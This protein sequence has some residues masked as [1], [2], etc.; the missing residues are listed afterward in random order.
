MK[1]ANY[2]KRT[3]PGTVFDICNVSFLL[4]LS[5]VLVYPFWNQLIISLNDGMDAQRGGLYFWPRVFTLGNYEYIFGTAGMLRSLGWSVLR[6]VVGTSTKLFATGMLAYITTV[7]YFSFH[8]QLRKLFLITMYISGGMIP[9]YL[10]MIK[11]H[12]IE[13]F[14]VYW[15]P[16]LLGAYEMMIIASY[17]ASLPDSMFESARMDGAKEHRI[18]LNIVL[19]LCVPV[20]AALGVMVA[21]GHWNSWFDVLIY[22]P[23]GNYDTLQMDLRNILIQS[24]KIKKL[25]Q[26]V[27]VGS[28]AVKSAA[29]RITSQSMRAATMMI[30]TIPIVAV[31]PF[32]Q[33]YFVKG[34][35]IG[36]VKG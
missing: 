7:R 5:F 4:V 23:S 32:F 21:V 29:A 11:L 22:N 27:T 35:S 8:R 17:I 28:A 13:T 14:T 6:V 1:K 34:I 16:S 30:V 9:I 26:D 33:K 36:A 3:T 31:Y 19:P 2:I 10:W 18:Y 24:D 25:M 12:L 20:F 15:L